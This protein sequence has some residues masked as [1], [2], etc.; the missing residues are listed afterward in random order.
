M[1]KFKGEGES[2]HTKTNNMK[3]AGRTYKQTNNLEEMNKFVGGGRTYE[4]TNNLD[5][6]ETYIHTNKLVGR[7]I[8]T[9]EQT[10]SLEVGTYKRTNKLVRGGLTYK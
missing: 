1:N 10:N 3:V 4:Q 7:D 9:N 2:T 5:V 6:G 8:H